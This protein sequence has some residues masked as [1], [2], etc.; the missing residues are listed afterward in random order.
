MFIFVYVL[1]FY[2]MATVFQLYNGSDMLYIDE[3]EKAYP[4][5]DSKDLYNPTPHRKGM[6]GTLL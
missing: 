6:I 2:A 4:F 3:K 1:L 5:T